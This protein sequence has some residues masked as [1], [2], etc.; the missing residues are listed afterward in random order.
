[1]SIALPPPRPAAPAVDHGRVSGTPLDVDRHAPEQRL[2]S[3]WFALGL[4][5]VMAA[6]YFFIGYR[7]TVDQH[8]VVFDALDRLTRAYLVWHNSPPKLAAVGFVFPPLTTFVFL[9]FAV[10]KPVATSLIALPLTSAVFAAATVA[11]LD[12]TLA[13]CDMP[14]LFRLPL[15][16]LFAFNPFWVFYAGNGMSEVVYCFFLAAGLY[17]FISW[18]ATTEP[19]YLIGAG[20]AI[21]TLVLVRY[22]FLI[23]GVLLGVLIAVA[24]VRRR[25]SSIEVEGSVI[26]FA[27]PVIYVMALWI[28]F[29]ALIIGEPFGWLTDA[30]TSAQAVNATGEVGAQNLGLDQ[31]TRRLFELNIAVFPLAFVAVPALVA[32]F[33]A[34]RNDMALWLAS[35]VVVGIVI[36]GV[37]SLTADK[38][39]LLTMR[40]AMPMYLAAFVGAAWVYRSLPA[41]RMLVLGATAV[42]LV[43]GLFTAWNGMKNYP[44]QN[45]EQAF[46]RALFSGDDQEGMPSRGGFTVGISS[47]A[48]MAQYIKTQIPQVRDSILTDNAQTFGV[49]MLSGRPQNFLDRI[50]KGDAEFRK[51]LQRPFGRVRYL[52]LTTNTRNS[53]DIVQQRYPRANQGTVDGLD[54]VFRTSRYVLVSVA[55]RAE[56]AAAA[57]E[58]TAA[59]GTTGTTGP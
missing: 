58:E 48:R 12:R 53:S 52:L 18:Y 21:A 32:T 16:A 9:P 35:F 37:H 38:E 7:V 17:Y 26:A 1:M 15:L 56:V 40:D 14:L 41:A 4:F 49:I 29:N 13:R 43:I 24:L 50:D 19:R 54:V 6:V 44:F 2:P 47:E 5:V 51:V 3:G 11:V 8:V 42:V 20:F 30:T 31:I 10:V 34:Q 22:G 45:Q 59:T 27:A 39:G 46:T 55:S 36:M 28:L 23:W 33:V 25:A 57:R